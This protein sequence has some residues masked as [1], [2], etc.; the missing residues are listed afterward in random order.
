MVQKALNVEDHFGEGETWDQVMHQI[1]TEARCHSI[2]KQGAEHV[3]GAKVTKKIRQ[4]L[5]SST[6]D[7]QCG[8]VR[9]LP[10]TVHQSQH[11]TQVPTC[12]IKPTAIRQLHYIQSITTDPGHPS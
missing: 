6:S 10:Y 7:L 3:D 11:T 8:L 4:S 12:R 1:A 9:G 5:P 2:S